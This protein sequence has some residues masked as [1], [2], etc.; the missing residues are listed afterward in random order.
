MH[1]HPLLFLLEFLRCDLGERMNSLAQSARARDQFPGTTPMQPAF[2]RPALPRRRQ[3]PPLQIAE[4]A[5]TRIV[6]TRQLSHVI[7]VKQTRSVTR[8]YRLDRFGI[9]L[10]AWLHFTLALN[11]RQHAL[12]F[13]VHLAGAGGVGV[14]VERLS[15]LVQP[16]GGVA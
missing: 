13:S 3:L 14:W 2:G 10:Q 15:D 5:F 7:R 8:R 12:P 1:T 16:I 9:R 6:G 11:G 4:L